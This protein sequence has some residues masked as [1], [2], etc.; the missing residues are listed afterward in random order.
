MKWGHNDGQIIRDIEGNKGCDLSFVYHSDTELIHF[1]VI[2]G[3]KL[4]WWNCRTR[5]E[6]E[7]LN[8]LIYPWWDERNLKPRFEKS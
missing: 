6:C 3:Y 4:T 7:H 8:K 5:G 1:V 2:G